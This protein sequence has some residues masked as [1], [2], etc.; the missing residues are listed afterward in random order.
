MHLSKTRAKV[1]IQTAGDL[2]LSIHTGIV[3]YLY[4]LWETTPAKIFQAWAQPS[5]QI[6]DVCITGI[7]F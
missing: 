1:Q 7:W 2:L 3:L 6:D 4:G 5:K